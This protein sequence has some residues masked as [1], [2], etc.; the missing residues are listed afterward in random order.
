MI[1]EHGI[2]KEQVRLWIRTQLWDV[3]EKNVSNAK[4]DSWRR[5]GEVERRK[6]KEEGGG[7]GREEEEKKEEMYILKAGYISRARCQQYYNCSWLK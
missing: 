7:L 4:P 6:E 2:L 3:R 1:V 5:K